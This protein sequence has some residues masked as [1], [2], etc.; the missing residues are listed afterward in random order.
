MGIYVLI[1]DTLNVIHRIFSMKHFLSLIACGHALRQ[2]ILF[3]DSR[4]ILN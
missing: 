1:V 2:L 3:R 4:D